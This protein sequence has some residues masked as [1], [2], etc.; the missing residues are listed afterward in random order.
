MSKLGIAVW[1]LGQHALNRILPAINSVQNLNLI[2]VCSRNEDK[3]A[4]CSQH[5]GCFGWID[6]ALML[7]NEEID[8]IYIATPIGVHFEGAM[9]VLSA[10]KNVWCEKP[11]T[12]NLND[13]E[14]LIEIAR[15][16]KLILLESFMYLYHPQFKAVQ[17]Y[18]HNPQNGKVHSITCRFGLPELEAPGFRTNLELGGGAFWDLAC[19]PV[20]TSLAIFPFQE[21][22]VLFAEV[23]FQRESSVDTSGRA[24]LRFSDDISLYIEWSVGTS[25]RNEIDVWSENGSFYTDKIFSK[26]E[27]YEPIYKLRDKQGNEITEKAQKSE[28]FIEMFNNFCNIHSSFHS[29]EEEYSKIL[30]R[31]LL[32]DQIVKYSN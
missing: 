1:G 31:A 30:R 12:C 32:M 5:W 11:L 10:G 6:E 22:E 29:V 17:D 2:G 14:I 13:T 3:V 23:L 20:S 15:Q 7:D 9:K 27:N 24:L 16:K 28:Q 25:Y 4:K 21:A 19:Y 26:H 18:I 8:V